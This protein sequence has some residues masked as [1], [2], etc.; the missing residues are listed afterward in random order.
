MPQDLLSQ[1]AQPIVITPGPRRSYAAVAA[2]FTPY[3]TPTDIIT[4]PGNP[5]TLVRLTRISLSSI[6]STG[7]L[8]NWK[9]IKRA[10]ANTGGT[11]APLTAVPMDSGYPAAQSIPKK[12]T[13]A[14]TINNTLGSIAEVQLL[15]PASTAANTGDTSIYLASP[16]GATHALRGATEELA[17]NFSGAAVPSGLSIAVLLEWTEEG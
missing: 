6:Q 13:A 9:L 5:N 12:W 1:G 15:T 4:L 7:G 8:N 17:L 16:L 14:P 11:S 3:A 2:A 10:A